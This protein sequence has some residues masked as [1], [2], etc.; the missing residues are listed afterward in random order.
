MLIRE[1]LQLELKSVRKD[2]HGRFVIVEALVQDSAVVLINIYAPNKT[3]EAID[4]YENLSSTLLESDYDQDYKFIMGGDF[5]API[6]LQLDSYGSKTEKR[7]VVTKIRELMLDFNLVDIWRLRNPDKK[8]YTWKQNKPLVQRRLD[9]WLI[10][11][12][13]QDDVDNTGIISAIK[14]DH[15]AIVLQVNSVERQPT[16]P[17]YWKFNSSLLDDP[18]Y[19]NLINDNVPLWLIEFSDVLDKGLL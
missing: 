8:R 10:S 1:T 5:N 9:Y 3:Y 14:T 15:S 16:G 2:N 17:S 19:I 12:D 7:D 13:F 6:S 18:E 4:F 11:D